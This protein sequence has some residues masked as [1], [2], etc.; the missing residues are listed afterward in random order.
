MELLERENQLA[1]LDTW[2]AEVSGSGQGQLVLLAGEAGAGKTALVRAFGARHVSVTV[3]TGGCE[4]LFTPRPL[5]PLL[6]IAAEVGGELAERT[7]SAGDA[8]VAL[9]RALRGPTIVVL[10]DLHWAD[11]ATLDVVRL[12]GRRVARLPALVIATYRDDELGPDHPLRTVLGDLRE[13]HR[14]AVEPLSPGAV[15]RLAAA[16]SVD[17]AGLHARTGGNAFFV[18]E[19]LAQ[20]GAG[21]PGSVRDAV[22]ARATRLRGPA[23]RLLEAVAVARPRAELWLL[24][25]VAPEELPQ[26][27]TCLA[28]GMLRAEGDAVGFRHEI[29]R[30]TLEDELPPDRRVSL[31]R[32]V[33]AALAGRGEPARLAHHAAA[34]GDDDAVLE[35]SQ[36]AGERATRLGAHREAAAHFAAALRHAG[37]LE[38]AARGGAAR[39]AVAG[40]LPERHDRRT[41]SRPRRWRS[42][43][44]S[45][46]ETGCGR[47]TRT[48]RSGCSPGTRATARATSRVRPR[49]S[50]SSRRCRPAASSRWPTATGRRCA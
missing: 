50:R 29:A 11:E 45:R 21:T 32:A 28:S 42:S 19:V 48:A 33:L 24:E 35:H 30:A 1:R 41:P 5:G 15:G 18:T 20:S 31:H 34:A 46:R 47:A 25:A 6:D 37:G 23:R 36:A 38:P 44:S 4:A 14:V 26:L 39:T 22:L 12:L 17:G 16:H 10:E 3:L 8:L 2:L 7:T 43:S 49:R 40:L 9:G 27:G 13:A